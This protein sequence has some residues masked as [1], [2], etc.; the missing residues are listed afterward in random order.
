VSY[1]PFYLVFNSVEQETLFCVVL[2]CRNL[3]NVKRIQSFLSTSFWGI[4][5]ALEEEVDQKT[6]KAQ[7]RAHHMGRTLGH[8]VGPTWSLVAP[9]ASILMAMNFP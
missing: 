2:S 9:F 1:S 8:M 4:Q 5:A 6:T 7:D 3:P